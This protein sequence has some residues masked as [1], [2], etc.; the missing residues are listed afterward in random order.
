MQ[1]VVEH[2]LRTVLPTSVAGIGGFYIAVDM[3]L[4]AIG[5]ITDAENSFQA[6]VDV[7]QTI[8]IFG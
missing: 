8:S 4:E 7:I 3:A 5:K 1:P 6:C 2:G